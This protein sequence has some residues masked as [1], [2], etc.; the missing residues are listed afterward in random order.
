MHCVF[1]I[2]KSKMCFCK[3]LVAVQTDFVELLRI[4][5]LR[6]DMSW[7]GLYTNIQTQ[8]PIVM[9]IKWVQF[10]CAITNVTTE[11][12]SNLTVYMPLTSENA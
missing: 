7:H 2:F 11:P 1:K 5:V 12:T 8:P 6:V 10:Q 9:P 3:F 4:T